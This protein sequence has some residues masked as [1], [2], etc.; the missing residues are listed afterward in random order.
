MSFKE[1]YLKYKNKYVNLKNQIGGSNSLNF[2]ESRMIQNNNLCFNNVVI[3]LFYSIPEFKNAILEN[4]SDSF[5]KKLF[6][7]MDKKITVSS[8]IVNDNFIL[9]NKDDEFYNQ[10]VKFIKDFY[11][12]ANN[13]D[14]MGFLNGEMGFLNVSLIN[15]MVVFS[16]IINNLFCYFIDNGEKIYFIEDTIPLEIIKFNKYLI[17]PP[18]DSDYINIKNYNIKLGEHN[19]ELVAILSGVYI[20]KEEAGDGYDEGAGG[21]YWLDIYNKSTKLYTMINDL[22]DSVKKDFNRSEN[23]SAKAAIAWLIYEKI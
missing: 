20:S 9:F 2:N 16:D 8:D 22:E 3:Y 19:Y 10:Y 15:F 4:T 7:L 13:Y 21:H 23:P 17:R 12:L 6:R 1:K 14:E 11:I 5:L 18:F